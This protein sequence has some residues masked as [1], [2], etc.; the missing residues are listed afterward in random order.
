[1]LS[2]M[3]KNWINVHQG[4]TQCT[5]VGGRGRYIGGG[6]DKSA[7]TDHSEGW[8]GKIVWVETYEVASEG[9]VERCRFCKGLGWTHHFQ[10]W[11][12]HYRHCSTTDCRACALG[13]SSANGSA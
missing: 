8:R 2:C 13:E 10:F 12:W 5:C 7:P 6:R 9:I 1:M 3:G 11:Q 4:E